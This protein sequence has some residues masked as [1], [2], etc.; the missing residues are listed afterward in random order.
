MAWNVVYGSPS[1]AVDSPRQPSV[2]ALILAGY[3]PQVSQGKILTPGVGSLA[4][5]GQ[6][7]TLASGFST[8][9]PSTLTNLGSPFTIGDNSGQNSSTGPQTTGGSPGVCYARAGDGTDYIAT[10]PGFTTTDH[11]AQHTVKFT[12]GYVAPG[13]QEIEL[14]LGFTLASGQSIGYEMDFWFAGA[15]LQPVRWNNG[16]NNDYDFAAVTT[17]S[18]SWPGS[19]SDGDV[20]R[21]HYRISGGNPLI[22]V[23]LNNALQITFT[24]TTAGKILS[25]SPGFGFFARTG[26]GYDPTKYCSKGF[27]C[28]N[29]SGP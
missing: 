28:G 9:W 25:G 15:T 11:W 10:V 5:A 19:L 7:P 13:T 14:L 8:T 18:G 6:A 20:I 27:A 2:A 3:A 22:D 26:T 21:G 12:S 29:G 24:D 23:F 17:V 16:H 4:L 1:G